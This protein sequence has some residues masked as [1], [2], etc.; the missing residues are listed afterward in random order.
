MA[1][2]LDFNGC[3]G[4]RVVKRTAG[5]GQ[6]PLGPF[7]TGRQRLASDSLGT[8][9]LVLKNVVAGSR[10][11]VELL[12]GGAV[13]TPSANA[14]GVVPGTPGTLVDHTI[15]LDYFSAGNSSNNLRVKVR[16]GTTVP[17][18]KPFETPA[19]AQAGTVLSY[20]AQEPDTI[21]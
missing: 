7:I 15:T 14:E 5:K 1:S 19:T 2:F 16:K 3:L 17:K 13:A 10:Y 11:R 21:A 9:S 20:I 12:V 4:G 18:Y 8:F 6:R